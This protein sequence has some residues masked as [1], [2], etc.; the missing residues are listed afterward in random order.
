LATVSCPA[1]SDRFT[2]ASYA[3]DSVC[4]RPL[5]PWHTSLPDW[6]AVSYQS[7]DKSAWSRAPAPTN[8][9]PTNNRLPSSVGSKVY[10]GRGAATI[11]QPV[12]WWTS[13]AL[14]ARVREL[15]ATVSC[16]APSDRLTVASYARDS[17]C[18]RPLPPWHTSLPDWCTVSYQSADK[19]AWSR[20]SAPTSEVPANNRLP[21]SVGSKVY[22]GRGA[23]TNQPVCWW[24][25]QA[26]EARVRE[27]LATVSCLATS[28]RLTVASYER[29]RL[30]VPKTITAM[31][32]KLVK[33][34]CCLLLKYGQECVVKSLD[35]NE[36]SSCQ[37]HSRKH[38]RQQ[39]AFLRKNALAP[40]T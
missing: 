37:Q 39:T 20:A 1:T 27:L 31:A 11:D 9:V 22:P 19:S 28:D 2:I 32:H 34:V 8:K 10:P 3:R 21:S 40:G 23:T 24:T 14:E 6:C 38:G 12:C 18:P 5:P 29:T 4:P 7:A 30:G 17:V 35:S 25:S 36:Q 26:L 15:L 16:P 13:Q 33:L